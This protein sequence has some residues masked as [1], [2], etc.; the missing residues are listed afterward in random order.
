LGFSALEK[1]WLRELML[2]C[3]LIGQIRFGERPGLDMSFVESMDELEA[4]AE[5]LQMEQPTKLMDALTQPTI[6]VRQIHRGI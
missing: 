3:L 1:A 2:A 5:L 6:R 4:L